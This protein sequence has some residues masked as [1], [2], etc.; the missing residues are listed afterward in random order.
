MTAAQLARKG[1]ASVLIE[2]SERPG[3]GAAYSTTDAAH[4]LN[5][6]AGNMSAW[7]DVPGDF[8]RRTGDSAQFAQRREYGAY[9]RTILDEAVSTGC[10]TVVKAA[11]IGAER[12]EI[13]WTVNLE[14]TESIAADAMVLAI[15]N[16]PPGSL[17]ALEG[18][19][20]RLIPNPWSDSARL[21]IA[22]TAATNAPVLIVGTGLT[23]VDVVLSLEAQGHRGSIVALSRRG[24]APRGHA[25]YEASPIAMAS[26]PAGTA[27]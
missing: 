7:A 8:A 24:Q 6:P 10:V 5:V 12:S 3:L 1:I 15:G 11:A 27:R 4:V 16:Q 23:M 18:A 19:G 21:A 17:A 26:V 2:R 20:D 22:E 14:G 25:A 13:G 9:L